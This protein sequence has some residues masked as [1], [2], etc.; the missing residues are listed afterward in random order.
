MESLLQ[1]T[2]HLFKQKLKSSLEIIN[3]LGIIL[4]LTV[5]SGAFCCLVLETPVSHLGCPGFETRGCS[6]QGIQ[7][8]WRGEVLLIENCDENRD[9]LRR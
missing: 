9:N 4:R 6:T 3:C 8:R 2:Q 1:Q 5:V 7:L